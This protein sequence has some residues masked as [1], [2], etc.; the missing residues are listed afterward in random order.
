[1]IRPVFYMLAIMLLLVGCATETNTNV[2]YYLLDNATSMPVHEDLAQRSTTVVVETIELA[3]YLKH[4]GLSMQLDEHQ[5]YYSKQHFWAQPLQASIQNA[6]IKDLNKNSNTTSFYTPKQVNSSQT[7]LTLSVKI[8]HFLPTNKSKVVL[9]GQYWLYNDH[10]Q[11]D[12]TPSMYH[13]KFELPLAKNGY[14]HAV[15]KL[16]NLVEDLSKD[17]INNMENVKN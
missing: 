14:G 7:D 10:H 6:L 5:V 4:A 16:R 13:F 2:Q 11:K 9:V 8:N 3:D 1:M 15:G 17:I 12:L